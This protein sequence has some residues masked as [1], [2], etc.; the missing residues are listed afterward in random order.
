MWIDIRLE[1][2]EVNGIVIEGIQQENCNGERRSCCALHL[3]DE[4]EI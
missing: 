1:L 4:H 2:N 3:I